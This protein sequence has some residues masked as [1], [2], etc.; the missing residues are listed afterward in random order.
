MDAFI[1]NVVG[2]L[3]YAWGIVLAAYVL[4]TPGDQIAAAMFGGS[5]VGL[6]AALLEWD[7]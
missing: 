1:R 7:S 6:G 3:C 5:L 4:I 2:R